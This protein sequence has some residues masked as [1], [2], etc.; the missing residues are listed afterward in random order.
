MGRA[1]SLL[2]LDFLL[3]TFYG[4]GT[5]KVEGVSKTKL[6]TKEEELRKK[7]LEALLANEDDED[8]KTFLQF[9]F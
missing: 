9:Y 7:E 2:A 3:K 6:Y 8:E 4:T 1:S 5:R